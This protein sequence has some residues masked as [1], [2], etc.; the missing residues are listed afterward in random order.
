MIDALHRGGHCECLRKEETHIPRHT[1][2]VSCLLNVI[3]C[4]KLATSFSVQINT[5]PL[6]VC[7]LKSFIIT[8]SLFFFRQHKPLGVCR[9]LFTF[10]LA[11][12]DVGQGCTSLEGP[13]GPAPAYLVVYSTINSL[14]CRTQ[15]HAPGAVMSAPHLR[16]TE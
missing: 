13:L 15:T 6:I 1:R 14:A 4:C 2:S 11:S 3:Y 7:Q 10:G 5:V 16:S 8:V 12:A 9:A